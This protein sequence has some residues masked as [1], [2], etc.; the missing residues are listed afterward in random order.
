MW[1]L[2]PNDNFFTM[3]VVDSGEIV[4]GEHIDDH[5]DPERRPPAPIGHQQ[6]LHAVARAATHHRMRNHSTDSPDLLGQPRHETSPPDTAAR[7][8]IERYTPIF[9]V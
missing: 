4:G 3:L 1:L 9:S 2:F 5:D 8:A 6:H 7:T